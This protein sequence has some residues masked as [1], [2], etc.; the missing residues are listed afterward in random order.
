MR[1]LAALTF[2]FVLSVTAAHAQAPDPTG[3]FDKLSPDDQTVARAIFGAQKTSAPKTLS[4]EQLAYRKLYD[5]KG[6]PSIYKDLQRQ[7]LVR[8]KS[9]N[10]AMK[11]FEQRN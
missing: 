11:T 9:L 8:E 6:W 10:Q 7:G 5:R 3:S 4:L 2:A 1:R